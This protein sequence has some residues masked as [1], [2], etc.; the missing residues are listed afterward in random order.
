MKNLTIAA[1]LATALSATLP[2]IASADNLGAQFSVE[3]AGHVDLDRVVS[4]T[5]GWVEILD[6]SSIATGVLLG[7]EDVRPGL[8]SDVRVQLTHRPYRDN[9]FAVLYDADGQ[10]TATRELRVSN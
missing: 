8:E 2:A 7:S 5:G 6:G 3:N 10:V 1:A 4:E 9:V